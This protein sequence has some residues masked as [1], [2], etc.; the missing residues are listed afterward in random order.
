MN[1]LQEIIN[2]EGSVLMPVAHD[3]LS[4]KIIKQVG[5]KAMSI[6][7]FA[8]SATRHGF[9]DFGI[10]SYKEMK[11]AISDIVSAGDL[12][13]LVDA[14]GGYGDFLNVERVIRDYEKEP[15]ISCI[16]LEDQVHP[17]RCGHLSGKRL[18]LIHI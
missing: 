6:G 13:C 9:P 1:K 11:D 17:K 3:A 14:D 5:F 7:G 2:T 8:I 16:F 4:A 10:V 18:S 12:P 15:N